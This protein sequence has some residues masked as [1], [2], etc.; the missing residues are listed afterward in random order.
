MADIN[1]SEPYSSVPTKELVTRLG[2]KAS[3]P[4][5][6]LENILDTIFA[7]LRMEVNEG[8]QYIDLI[9]ETYIC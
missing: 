5:F 8:L 4:P 7:W 2:S 1:T 3:F 6:P 9:D